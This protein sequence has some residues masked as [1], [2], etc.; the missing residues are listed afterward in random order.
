MSLPPAA[1]QVTPDTRRGAAAGPMAT[2]PDPTL[3]RSAGGQD[4]PPS[5]WPAK[6]LLGAHAGAAGLFRRGEQGPAVA[7]GSTGSQAALRGQVTASP[8]LLRS[9]GWAV[10]GRCLLG[11]S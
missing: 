1:T 5:P 3:Q 10:P 4:W 2:C 8:S 9:E 6:G 7:Q 11:R